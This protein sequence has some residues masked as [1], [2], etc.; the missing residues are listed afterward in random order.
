[1]QFNIFYWFKLFDS[2]EHSTLELIYDGFYNKYFLHYKLEGFLH[3]LRLKPPGI[4][5]GVKLSLQ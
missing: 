5:T 4:L 3:I 1:M 2:T